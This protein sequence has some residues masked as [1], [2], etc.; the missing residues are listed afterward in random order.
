MFGF[1]KKNNC[2]N[3]QKQKQKQSCKS[4]HSKL[5][6]AGKVVNLVFWGLCCVSVGQGIIGQVRK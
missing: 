5:D 2:Q 4:E 1:S 3:K 6:T